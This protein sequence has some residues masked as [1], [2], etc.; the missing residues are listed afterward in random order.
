MISL[1]CR[2]NTSRS[3]RA[4]HHS[5]ECSSVSP[6][7]STHRSRSP[8]AAP[9]RTR[10]RTRSRRSQLALRLGATGLESDVWLT[11]DG[12]PVLDHDGVVGP[13]APPPPDRRGRARRP[14]RPHPLDRRPARR[15]RNRLRAV[16]RP[17]GSG[18]CAP[19]D[20]R[21]AANHDPLM[22]PRVWLCDPAIDRLIA[23]RPPT[24]RRPPGQLDTAR[25]HQGGTGTASG[26]PGPRGDR[27]DQ[28]APHRLERRPGHA[29]PPLRTACLLLGHAARAPPPREPADGRRCRLQRRR[30][31]H[32][33]RDGRRG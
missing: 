32:A 10:R 11:A 12:V 6:P 21:A 5:R 27:R 22:L 28:H 7:C 31:R 19:D 14:P 30:R 25:T 3:L 24:P 1:P 20:R 29:V 2:L 13:R 9:A 18:R 16:A 33:R 26:A 8:T 17:Q 4:C 15:M 23:L